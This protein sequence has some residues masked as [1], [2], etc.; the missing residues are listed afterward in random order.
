MKIIVVVVSMTMFCLSVGGVTMSVDSIEYRDS[1]CALCYETITDVDSVFIVNISTLEKRIKKEKVCILNDEEDRKQR[2]FLVAISLMS[3]RNFWGENP[4]EMPRLDKR[5]LK[6]IKHWYK[7]HKHLITLDL[8][9]RFYCAV[10]PPLMEL[11]EMDRF[12]DEL[13]KYVIRE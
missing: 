2:V 8:L 3:G 1:W 5:L 10:Y 12:Y 9:R 4:H 7:K 11:D 6:E 13:D